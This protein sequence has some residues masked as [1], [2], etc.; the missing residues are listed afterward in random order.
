MAGSSVYIEELAVRS[1]IQGIAA[2]GSLMKKNA[3]TGGR[4]YEEATLGAGLSWA[5]SVLNAVI[6]PHNDLADIQGGAA[7][8][9]YHLILADY[10]ALIDAN[11]QLIDLHTDGVLRLLH[12]ILLVILQQVEL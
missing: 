10:N 4:E 2:E 3:V 11:A 12:Y 8:A 1:I 9:Y 6:S 7:D 5:G